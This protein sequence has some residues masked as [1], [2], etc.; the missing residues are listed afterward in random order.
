MKF[1]GLKCI[2]IKKFNYNGNKKVDHTNR[3]NLLNQ[4]FKVDKPSEKWVSDITY[5]YTKQYGWTY[6]ATILDLFDLQIIGYEYGK[7]ITT[8]RYF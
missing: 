7:Y 4:E 1:L 6:L 2:T 5:I 3:S 8:A